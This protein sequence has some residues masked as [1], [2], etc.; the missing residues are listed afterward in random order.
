M[1]SNRCFSLKIK[2]PFYVA[3]KVRVLSCLQCASPLISIT[4]YL[5]II[6]IYA[7]AT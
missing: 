7:D 6:E 5:I 3:D 1:A 4:K 2:S